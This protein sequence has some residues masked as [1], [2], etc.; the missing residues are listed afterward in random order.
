[1]TRV[2]VTATGTDVGKTFV[3]C[4]LARELLAR[5][6]KLRVLKPVATGFDA[7]AVEQSD[8][9]RLLR[10][11]GLPPDAANLD[12]TTP[13][14]FAA[15]LS[16]DMAA[17]R[18]NRSLSFAELVAFCKERH[19]VDL[20]L[21]EGIGGVM[22]PLDAKHTVLD[23]IERLKAKVVLVA[24]SYLGTLSHTLTAVAS[25]QTRGLDPVAIVISESREQPVPLEETAE[26]VRQRLRRVPIVALSRVAGGT[27]SPVAAAAVAA[28]A[29]LLAPPRPR[30]RP[31]KEARPS[32]RRAGPRGG[33]S[34]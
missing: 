27:S 13:W 6:L 8:S 31:Q 28:L 24:G 12:A 20:T 2:F 17:R 7:R 18:E 3:V 14:R 10:A 9:G 19:D 29:D 21:I 4:G 33:T 32:S 25:L 15:P 16:P 11:Q 30:R 22:V 5:G 1:V 26:A 34:T 23:W